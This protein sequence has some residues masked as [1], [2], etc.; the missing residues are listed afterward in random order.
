MKLEIVIICKIFFILMNSI[1]KTL[2]SSVV[3]SNI[4]RDS[5]ILAILTETPINYHL[6]S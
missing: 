3:K 1:E 6:S 4:K 5:N 2:Y